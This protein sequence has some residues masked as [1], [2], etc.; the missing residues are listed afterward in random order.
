M[1]FADQKGAPKGREGKPKVSIGG[2]APST[3]EDHIFQV[4]SQFGTVV[5]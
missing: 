2:L 1:K 4:A 3:T 5:E